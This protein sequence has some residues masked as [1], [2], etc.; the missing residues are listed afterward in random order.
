MASS[1]NEFFYYQHLSL[2]IPRVFAN[3]TS[4]RIKHVFESLQF[5]KVFDVELVPRVPSSNGERTNMAFVH[6]TYWYYTPMVCAFQ[7]KV[8]N[9]RKE[10]RVIYDDPFYWLILP[11]R[12]GKHPMDMV[13]ERVVKLENRLLTTNNNNNLFPQNVA[14]AS[15]STSDNTTPKINIFDVKPLI[16]HCPICLCE[17]DVHIKTCEVCFAPLDKTLDQ[18]TWRVLT[19]RP[20]SSRPE[21]IEHARQEAL[22]KL[23]I[24]PENLD[25]ESE[26]EEQIVIQ[27]ES[28]TNDSDNWWKW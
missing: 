16:R 7:A 8:L 2:F 11:N 14:E 20:S 12:T 3:I 23:G 17:C 21:A 28:P 24:N 10:A 1:S 18:D 13:L 27:L 6:F 5:G 26:N 22:L 15:S 25:N 19:R 9:P 4:E